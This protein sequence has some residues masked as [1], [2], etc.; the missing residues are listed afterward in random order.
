[1]KR[2]SAYFISLLIFSCFGAAT[3]QDTISYNPKIRVAADIFGPVYY[4][5]DKNL[6]S[7]EGF[8]SVDFD[9]NKAAVIEIGYLDYIYSQYNYDFLS[10]GYFMRLGVDFNTLNPGTSQGKYYAGIGLRYG[11]S[12]FRAETPFLEHENYWGSVTG[13]A[14]PETSAAHSIELS[15]GIRTEL[16]SNVSIGWTIRLRILV[17]SGTGKDLKSIYIPGYGNGTKVFSPGINY[18]IIWSIPYRKAK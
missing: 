12:I 13:F 16:F 14:P 8:L 10:S 2:I 18:Y 5:A 15:P 11:L 3:G 7:L 1:M 6:L 9:T 17:Y 4:I